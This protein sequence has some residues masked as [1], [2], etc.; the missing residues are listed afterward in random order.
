MSIP[1][2]KIIL[3]SLGVVAA[4]KSMTP[5]QQRAVMDFAEQLAIAAEQANIARQQQQRALTS[6]PQLPPLPDPLAPAATGVE[7]ALG[8]YFPHNQPIVEAPPAAKAPMPLVE[9]DARWRE[10]IVP[11]AVM[12]VLG[13][14]GSGKSALG[15]RLLELFR[16]QLAPYVVG[17]PAQAKQLLPDWIGLA[18]ALEE[19]PNKSMVLIDEA[20]LAYHARE[21]LVGP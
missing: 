15:Y 19:L 6:A 7:E 9:P 14:R 2:S 10:V 18:P 1:W 12:L 4:W 8:K 21:S 3:G 20:Y 17:A 11:P 13:K 16:H 5:A